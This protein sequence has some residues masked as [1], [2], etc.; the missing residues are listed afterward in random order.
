MLI[1]NEHDD[2]LK[3]LQIIRELITQEQYVQ[4]TN[5][6]SSKIELHLEILLHLP[7]MYFNSNMRILVFLIVYSISRECEKT[8]VLDICNM[9]FSGNFIS[10]NMCIKMCI[11]L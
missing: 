8:Q 9:I 2:M 4:M 3:V 10:L 7:T 5:A 6:T 1:E 11:S